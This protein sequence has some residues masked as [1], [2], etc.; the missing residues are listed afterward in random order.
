MI[1][2]L[3]SSIADKGSE[4]KID[5]SA[6]RAGFGSIRAWLAISLACIMACELRSHQGILTEGFSPRL[7]TER[8]AVHPHPP[9]GPGGPILILSS[10]SNPYSRYYSEILLNEGLN[11]FS[12][13][14]IDEVTASTLKDF[15]VVILGEIPINAVQRQMLYRWVRLGGNLIAMRPDPALARML[16][17]LSEGGTLSDAYLAIDSWAEAGQGLI[18]DT[19]Q[20]HGP[21]DLYAVSKDNE[22]V[23]TLY[24]DATSSAAVPAIVSRHIGAGQFAV[25]TYDLARS[26]VYTRQGNPAW[27]GMERDGIPPMRSDDLFYGAASGDVQSDW[28]DLNKVAIPQ[29]DVQQRLLVNLILEMNRGKKPL[30]RFWYL[31]RGVK[32]VVIMTGD[33]HGHGGTAGRFR[34]F[35]RESPENCSVDEW[36][37]IRGTS[38]IYPG[39]ISAE[40]AARFV[41]K[42]FEIGLHE[43]T[44][45]KDWPQETVRNRDG[46]T[47]ARDSE[48]QSNLLYSQQLAAFAH[49]YPNLPAPTTGRTDCIVWGDFDTQPQV[50]L[51]HGIRLDMNYY[52]WPPKWVRNR[53]GM[54]TG[55]GMPMRFAKLDGSIIDVYQAATQMTDESGQTFPYTVDTLL[56]NALSSKEF[57]GVFTVNMHT[58]FA[59]SSGAD[60]IVAS[61]KARGVPIVS[62]IQMLRW[63]D[64]RNG[65]SFQNIR[66]SRGNLQ[67]SVALAEGSSGIQALLPLASSNG[68][69]VK[70]AIDGVP[71]PF[72]TV[73]IAGHEYAEFPAKQGDCVARYSNRS[74]ASSDQ[75]SEPV[76]R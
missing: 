44:G 14:E 6:R 13:E 9:N 30:P 32:A 63:L 33:D 16:G 2:P 37:C 7:R 60:A 15:D 5:H 41:S 76:A 20:F 47:G 58:D 71:V 27:S 38:N 62:A 48:Q 42:G 59:Q 34:E 4:S 31:P 18:Q 26:V 65:S 67:F 19:I 70:I 8:S 22:S 74:A 68:K 73:T 39:S 1:D 25:F 72:R 3:E 53:P 56:D 64:G 45:C 55:S 51:Q 23:A 49:Y 11:E 24:R 57:Y 36:Q 61:A 10:A 28:V 43:Y 75:M 12:I 69:L 50:E 66:W 29:A 46:S 35:E 40:V 17:L 52:Y 54:F 21:A